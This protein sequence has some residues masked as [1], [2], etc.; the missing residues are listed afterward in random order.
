MYAREAEQNLLRESLS[1]AATR[2][3]TVRPSTSVSTLWRGT[4]YVEN[5]S[6]SGQTNDVVV[7]DMTI[8]GT[9]ALTYTS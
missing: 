3:F 7:T 6:V 5:Y 2:Y 1:S 8:R 9:R 4:G